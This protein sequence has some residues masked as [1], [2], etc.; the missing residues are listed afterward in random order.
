M[1]EIIKV[2]TGVLQFVSKK[3]LCF[4]LISFIFLC[5][6]YTK[7]KIIIELPFNISHFDD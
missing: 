3:D 1:D 5:T 7:I 4:K 6:L 2:Y